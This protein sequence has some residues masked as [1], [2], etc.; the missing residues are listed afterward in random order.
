MINP[1]LFPFKVPLELSP[2]SLHS[3]S[4]LWF[5]VDLFLFLWKFEEMFTDCLQL[6]YQLRRNPVVHHLEYSPFVASVGDETDQVSF[7]WVAQINGGNFGYGSL[8][9]GDCG[10]FG[11]GSDEI[12]RNGIG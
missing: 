9:G 11:F 4:P 1:T 2:I 5:S 12:G 3:L 7:I 8:K 10:L 6:V